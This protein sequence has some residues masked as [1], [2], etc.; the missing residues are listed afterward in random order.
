VLAVHVP[1]VGLSVVPV[2]LGWPMVLMPVHILFLQLVI[3]PVCSIVFEAEP[4]EAGA[5]RQPP[6]APGARLF[7]RQVLGRGLLQGA[8]LLAIVLAA[9]AHARAVSGS[10]EAARALTFAVLVVASLALIQANRRWMRMPGQAGP[11]NAAFGA[12]ALATL[13]LLAL[14]LW[15]PGIAALFAFAVPAPE[16]LAAGAGLCLLAMV[17]F[18]VVRRIGSRSTAG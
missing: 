15:V 16:L 18:E 17:W 5:M 10:D 2:L 3:D 1:I 6:R 8:G 12:I 13:S 14:V 7:D 11:W 4:L 9:Y